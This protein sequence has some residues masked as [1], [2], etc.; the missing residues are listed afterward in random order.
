M[1]SQPVRFQDL[2]TLSLL[3]ETHQGAVRVYPAKHKQT[4]VVCKVRDLDT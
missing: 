1:E 2:Q 4:A 3:E